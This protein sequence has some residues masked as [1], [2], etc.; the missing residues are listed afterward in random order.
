MVLGTPAL[1]RRR[2]PHPCSSRQNF[3][4]ALPHPRG[5]EHTAGNGGA[6]WGRRLTSNNGCLPADIG[7]IR[8]VHGQGPQELGEVVAELTVGWSGQE[9]P[10]RR[11]WGQ[12][13]ASWERDRMGSEDLAGELGVVLRW[14]ANNHHLFA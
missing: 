12:G 1:P 10:T 11:V 6:G 2:R 9:K 7:A 4:A 14:G 3:L 5:A 8:S 13:K